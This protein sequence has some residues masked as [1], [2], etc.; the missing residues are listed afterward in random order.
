MCRDKQFTKKFDARA[1]K[2]I[3]VGYHG[4]SVNY[5][6]YNSETRKVIKSLRVTFHELT[7]A[8]VP[9]EKEDKRNL[10]DFLY[11]PADGDLEDT[12]FME[13]PEGLNVEE[14]R[15]NSGVISAMCKLQ[16]SLYG[17]KQAPRCWNHTFTQFLSKF[18]LKCSDADKCVF[19][20]S[21][22]GESVYL[23]L[24]IDDGLVAAKSVKTLVYLA[25]CLESEFKVTFGNSS[26]FVGMQIESMRE[27]KRLFIYQSAYIITMLEKFGMSNAKAMSV[28]ADPNVVLYAVNEND[29]KLSNVPYLKAV[30]S[31][32]F[33]ASVSRPDISFFVNQVSKFL[34]NHNNEHWHAVKIIFAYLE[35]TI[36]LG[37]IHGS[38]GSNFEL[39]GF[40]DADFANDIQMRRSCILFS[41]SFSV[42]GS[43]SEIGDLW[44][45]SG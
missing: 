9:P 10:E 29:E 5:R 45:Y 39:I 7:G 34:N 1:E 20:G 17:L 3:S 40:S 42:M 13:I 12:I 28:P 30:G 35:R 36:D 11:F 26:F 8:F 18:D 21:R 25:E 2:V 16:K 32:V 43:T 22:N 33:S 44:H 24:F 14:E 6:L 37:I 19:A 15:R 23:V 41:R 38:G 31:L 4:N 27:S